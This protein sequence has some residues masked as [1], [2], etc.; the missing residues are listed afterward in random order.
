MLSTSRGWP[1]CIG[2][3][4]G[5]LSSSPSSFRL[6]LHVCSLDLGSLSQFSQQHPRT[7]SPASQQRVHTRNKGC[8]LASENPDKAPLWE[9]RRNVLKTPVRIPT[10]L[11]RAS[12][13]LRGCKNMTGAALPCLLLSCVILISD[14]ARTAIFLPW[15]DSDG[16]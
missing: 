7:T 9:N 4:S 11:T 6:S 15:T 8:L 12:S 1:S 5:S 13:K 16:L 10:E 14:W 3:L 2:I